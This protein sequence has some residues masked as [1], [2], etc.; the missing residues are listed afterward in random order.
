M[1]RLQNRENVSL[2]ADV[3]RQE[4]INQSLQVQALIQELQSCA[5]P[6]ETLD[7]ISLEV[8][9]RIAALRKHIQELEGLADELDVEKDRLQLLEESKSHRQMLT[10][11]QTAFRNAT[12]ACQ[13]VIDKTNQEQLFSSD[14]EPMSARKRLN[15]DKQSMANASANVTDHLLS[16]SRHLAETN[17]RSADTL[18]NLAN[19]SYTLHSTQEEFKNMGGVINQSGK[20]LAKYGRRELTDKVIVF[21]AFA[22]FM[23]CVL[24]I[25]KKRLF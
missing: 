17:Q 18:E 10:S 8:R 22:F 6:Q 24:Y 15:K 7:A 1:H 21:F 2:F 14:K 13:H 25:I 12:V 16:I 23:A 3:T 19:S 20:L 5:G 9:T 11:S 4:I